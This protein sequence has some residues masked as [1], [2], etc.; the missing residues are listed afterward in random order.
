MVAKAIWQLSTQLGEGPGIASHTLS[1]GDF[2][3]DGLVNANDIDL[4]MV[5]VLTDENRLE[6]DLTADGQAALA[7]VNSLVQEI[8][9][10][11]SGDIDLDGDVDFVSLSNNFLTGQHSWTRGNFNLD[12]D[13]NS[14]D[15]FGFS[16]LFGS[17]I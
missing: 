17:G 4:L 5:E 6:F 8:L 3:T 14:V 16:K 15:F 1:E 11:T 9:Q 2:G 10:T 7:D 12:G 13:V